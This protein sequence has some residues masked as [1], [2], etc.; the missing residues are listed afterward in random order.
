MREREREREKEKE[1]INTLYKSVLE[2][3][4]TKREE[5]GLTQYDISTAL[6]LSE[7]GY[8]KVEKGKTKLDLER[9]F[10]ILLKLEISPEEFF[11]GIG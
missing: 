1:K 10:T 11:K 6:G 9:L 2:K 8:F 4:V 5:A 7:S 3:L